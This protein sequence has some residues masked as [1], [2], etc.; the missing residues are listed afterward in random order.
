MVLGAKGELGDGWTYDI[1]AQ[2]SLTLYQQLYLNDFSKEMSQNALQVNPDGTCK[3]GGDCVPLDVFHGVGS[4][5]PEMLNYVYSHGQRTG[6]TEEQ[7]LEATIAGDLGQYGV[8]SPWADSGVGIAFGGLY[9]KDILEEITSVADFSGDLFGAGAPAKG[10]PKSSIRVWEVYSEANIPLIT[11]MPWIQELKAN[12]G[13]RY[14]EYNPAGAARAYKYGL[15][16][17]PIDDFRLRA[18]ANRAVRAPNVLELFQPT[19]VA[20]SSYEDP[21]A[22][23]TP[24]ATLAGCI[25]SGMTAA[26]YGNTIQCPAS[27]C[28]YLTG[29][30][31]AL[32]PE[33]S[34]TK[35]FG[36]VLTPTF[37]PGFSMTVDYYNI[38]VKDYVGTV[39]Q[40]VA[41][42]GCT[43][44]QNTA[45]CPLVH[46]GSTGALF[47]PD[48]YVIGTNVNTGY[49]KTSGIDVE[50]N[51]QAALE[52]Y[53][54]GDNGALSLHMMG[55]YVNAYKV[56]PYTGASAGGK[57]DYDCVGLY[58][59]SCGTP[60]YSWRHTARATWST[61]W[62]FDFSLG[63]RHFSASKF[64]GN[65][66]SAYLKQSYVVGPNGGGKIA[67]YDYLDVATAINVSEQVVVNLG[68][69][70][71]FDKDPPLLASG[72]KTTGQTGPLNGNTLNGI[73]DALGRYMFMSISI[74]S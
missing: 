57:P 71:V 24:S 67:D 61:P 29:G 3:V 32:K 20:L 66:S 48:G 51:Y 63:W 34:D 45:L 50:A 19:F 62:S 23:A 46:R 22:G 25:A 12:V 64:D 6:S 59:I 47:T 35:S 37:L 65:D 74:K 58:G 39:S 43:T 4:I 56:Q 52:D 15:E 8:K 60:T 1:S 21:C 16:W 31:V 68:I 53:G 40:A 14:S 33:I 7:V 72:G 18:S 2:E 5:T 42:G 55:T 44:L 11:G 27:Q 10:Q 28:Q 54:L 70:N 26:Q 36:I 73:Y 30:N 69:N 49:L 41:I 38:Y 17:Q 9:R 13:Y